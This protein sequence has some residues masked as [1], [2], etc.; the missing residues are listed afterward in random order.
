M[1]DLY[2]FLMH[3][4]PGCLAPETK[5]RYRRSIKVNNC[6]PLAASLRDHR[7][8]DFWLCGKDPWRRVYDK[9]DYECW[10]EYTI[11]PDFEEESDE[12]MQ[13]SIDELRVEIHSPYDCTGK[14][15]SN[16]IHWKRTKAGVVIIR[17]MSLDV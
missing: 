4:N 8:K 5:R 3:M 12:E 2:F 11:M 1:N 17:H 6:D 9:D 13:R 16:F 15:F 10:R 14:P 7:W